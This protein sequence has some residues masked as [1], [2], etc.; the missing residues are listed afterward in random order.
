MATYYQKLRLHIQFQEFPLTV[1]CLSW[2]IEGIALLEVEKFDSVD[3]QRLLP[4]RLQVDQIEVRQYLVVLLLVFDQLLRVLL[5]SEVADIDLYIENAK[6]LNEAMKGA[7]G[8]ELKDSASINELS[9]YT[10]ER[11][12]EQREAAEKEM[13]DKLMELGVD[14]TGLSMKEMKEV[15]DALSDEKKKPSKEQEKV[16]RDTAKKAFDTYSAIIKE[17][18]STKKDPFTG[19]PIEFTETQRDLIERFMKMDLDLL[20]GKES[21]AAANSLINFITNGSIS[22]MG[23]LVS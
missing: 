18:L 4:I 11:L 9:E 21:I 12:T 6:K 2:D 20:S 19:E 22:K 16:A 13:Q 8:K 17:M 5:A 15:F 7:F 14:A 3:A 23:K 1:R 10:E